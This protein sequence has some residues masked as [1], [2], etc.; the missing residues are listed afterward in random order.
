[1]AGKAIPRTSRVKKMAEMSAMGKVLSCWVDVRDTG[2]R[3]IKLQGGYPQ[4]IRGSNK[5][6]NK[7]RGV[8]ASFSWRGRR[9]GFNSFG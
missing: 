8:G 2:V 9:M 7:R 1:M 6:K 4:R 5:C 3:G